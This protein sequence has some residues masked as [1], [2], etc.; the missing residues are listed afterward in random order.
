MIRYNSCMKEKSFPSNASLQVDCFINSTLTLEKTWVLESFLKQTSTIETCYPSVLWEF[1]FFKPDNLQKLDAEIAVLIWM[2]GC[3]IKQPACSVNLTK[4]PEVFIILCCSWWLKPEIQE[5][6]VTRLGPFPNHYRRQDKVKH[7][8][9][10]RPFYFSQID[11][12]VAHQH[13][14][15]QDR[16]TDISPFL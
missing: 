1:Q 13:V 9:H 5:C 6:G 14:L 16:W 10:H 4:Q 3:Y 12:V 8:L 11:V 15:C 7:C 2:Q